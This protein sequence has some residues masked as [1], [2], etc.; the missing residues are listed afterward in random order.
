MTSSRRVHIVGI[1][2]GIRLHETRT[3]TLTLPVCDVL[4]RAL[5]SDKLNEGTDEGEGKEEGERL[6]IR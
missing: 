5:I 2:C 4:F 6:D 1:Q 3:H